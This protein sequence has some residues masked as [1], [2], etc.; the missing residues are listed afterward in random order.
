M[1]YLNDKIIF[2]QQGTCAHWVWR[3]YDETGE[4]LVGSAFRTYLSLQEC[5]DAAIR[6][7]NHFDPRQI[8]I[9]LKQYLGV[10]E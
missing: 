7:N 8:Q 5:L 1:S 2:S 6:A 9:E 4:K 10:M 3:R